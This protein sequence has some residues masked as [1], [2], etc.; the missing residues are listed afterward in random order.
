[1][2]AR[3]GDDWVGHIV[4]GN[5]ILDLPEIGISVPPAEL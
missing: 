1:M 3:V 5:T 4:S 2:F